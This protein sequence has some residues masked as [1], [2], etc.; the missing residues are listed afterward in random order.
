MYSLKAAIAR[1]VGWLIHRVKATAPRTHLAGPASLERTAQTGSVCSAQD[2]S[3]QPQLSPAKP[4]S[5][6]KL[7]A[8]QRTSAASKSTSKKSKPA[9]TERSQRGRGSSTQ[10]PASKTHQPALQESKAKPK[11]AQHTKAALKPTHAKAPAKTRTA[12]PSGAAG[13]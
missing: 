12:R 7:K 11:R 10:T 13:S 9:Q 6:K 1:L 5:P 8:A 3:H 4:A 2:T